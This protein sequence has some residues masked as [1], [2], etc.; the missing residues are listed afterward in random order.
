VSG[1]VDPRLLRHGRA[2]RGY[3]LLTV[4]LGIATAVLVVVRAWLIAEIV[5]GAAADGKGLAQL[6]TALVVLLAVVVARAAVAWYGDV[7]ADRC[8]ARVKS[9]L[10]GALA[11]RVAHDAPSALS[12]QRT[13]DLVTLATRGIDAL[14][15]YFSRYLPQL[16][17]AV[18]VPLTVLGVVASRDWLSAL[19]I[20]VTLPLVPIFMVLIGT[21]TRSHT[22]R[23][24]RTLQQLSGHFLDVVAGLPTL[25]VFGRSKAQVTT[26][27]AVTDRYRRATMSTLRLA[28]LSALVLELLAS[29]AVALVAVS[30]GLRL[31]HGDVGFQTALLVLILAPEAY[32]PLRAV[33]THFHASAE[34]LSAA[35]QVFTVLE[36]PVPR[37]GQRA[38]A[39][40][41]AREPLVVE[42]LRVDLPG[43]DRPALDGFRLELAP[44]EV[45]AL[46]GPSGC[47]KSTLLS[48][49]LGFVRPTT[50]TARV[51]DVDLAD[52]DPEAWRRRVAWVPQRPYLFATSIEANVRLGR[53]DA[54]ALDVDAAV[55]AAGLERVVAGLPAGLATVLGERGLGLS[56]G[57]RQRVALAR[58]FLRDAPLLLLDEPTASL[59]GEVEAEILAAVRRL[60]AGRTVLLVAHRPALAALA[61]RIVTMDPARVSA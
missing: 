13:G 21:A 39:P 37:R 19:I 26:I 51:G 43:R 2:T 61:D 17:L 40:D 35:E 34:G 38:E 42:D 58:A 16:V 32:L 41:P 60:A 1:P 9:Q 53:P 10:R 29:V 55:A 25:K 45:V 8:S 44:G 56:A 6:R 22:D 14:D 49:L 57:E 36:R 12:G 28:F 24:L 3:L 33:G 11:E 30:I 18:I 15:G 46:T 54:P 5:V 20:A 48:V 7:A 52:V 31:L 59:D 4:A 50:G 23:Q 47:G 27:R